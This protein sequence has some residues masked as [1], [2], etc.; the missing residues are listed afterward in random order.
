M[1]DSPIPPVLIDG[2]APKTSD[3]LLAMLAGLDIDAPTLDHHPVYTV[4]EAAALRPQLPG[5]HT[6][7][8]FLRNRKKRMWLVTLLAD[9]QVDLK[10]LGARIGAGRVSFGSPQRL[11]QYLGL[12]PGAVSPLAVVNDVGGSVT[13]VL[14]A[15]VLAGPPIQVHPLTNARTTG[16]APDDLLR[17]VEAV[18]HPAQVVEL[19]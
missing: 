14:D 13:L 12:T 10:E 7:N 15:A 1:S 18:G 5:V 17:F 6:K 4:A 2:S 11:M 8:L 3:E 9:R 16:L 19:D